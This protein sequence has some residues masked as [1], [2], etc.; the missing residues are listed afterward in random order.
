[1]AA[2]ATFIDEQWSLCTALLGIRELGEAHD[3][4]A[5]STVLM[6]ITTSFLGLRFWATISDTTAVNPATAAR[7]QLEYNR[8][9][10]HILQR[11]I[12][13]AVYRKLASPL[14]HLEAVISYFKTSPCASAALRSKV[15]EMRATGLIPSGTATK[16][17]KMNKTR[18]T[19]TMNAV[20]RC[21]LFLSAINA[22]V[23]DRGR[24]DL[25]IRLDY[26]QDL[27]EIEFL[28]GPLADITEHLEARD[29]LMGEVLGV[30]VAGLQIIQE[31]VLQ[32][33]RTQA[34]RSAFVR[35][36][37]DRLYNDNTLVDLM[38]FSLFDPRYE[39]W[40]CI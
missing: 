22:V 1:V 25:H 35:N 19:S 23:G 17:V 33:E 10:I 27:P 28:L 7:L 21:R 4:N 16:L 3:A 14:D 26:A 6:Q 40:F 2:I 15:M 32:R 37:L 36:L 8:C 30:L 18:W 24:P 34:A 11:A 12:V 5:L 29:R 39:V 9:Q 20:A 13:T 38:F 31:L